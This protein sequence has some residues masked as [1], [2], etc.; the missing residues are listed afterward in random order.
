MSPKYPDNADWEPSQAEQRLPNKLFFFLLLDNSYTPFNAKD[1]FHFLLNTSS[2]RRFGGDVVDYTLM[3]I[4]SRH[5]TEKEPH[6]NG[7]PPTTNQ[8]KC[9]ILLLLSAPLQP[10]A[11]PRNVF[12]LRIQ[13]NYVLLHSVISSGKYPAK[14]M[15]KKWNEEG[16]IEN[17]T[18]KNYHQIRP[19]TPFAMARGSSLIYINGNAFRTLANTF[20]FVFFCLMTLRRENHFIIGILF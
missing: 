11:I 4:I 12:A 9:R 6:N 2:C 5:P 19:L 15:P 20:L 7:R 8:Q 16:T 18:R 3:I 14:D 13:P 1:T 10:N 17:S